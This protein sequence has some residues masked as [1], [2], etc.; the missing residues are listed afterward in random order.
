[1]DGATMVIIN[2]FQYMQE[3]ER[4]LFKVGAKKIH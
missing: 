3:K 1:M 4:K 2:Y